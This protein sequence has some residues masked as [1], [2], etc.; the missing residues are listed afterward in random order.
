MLKLKELKLLRNRI[1]TKAFCTWYKT[2]TNVFVLLVSRVDSDINKTVQWPK[3][4]ESL[5]NYSNR[6][7]LQGEEHPGINFKDWLN[8]HYFSVCLN[9]PSPNFQNFH[10][11]T[12]IS[13][14]HRTLNPPLHTWR[15]NSLGNTEF[16]PLC[17]SKLKIKN[18]FLIFSPSE[19]DMVTQTLHENSPF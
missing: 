15:C 6:Q 10:H 9:F 2:A 16:L 7:E 5:L 17:K 1:W 12:F 4:R 14:K 18:F 13:L 11:F 3:I 8:L 19:A